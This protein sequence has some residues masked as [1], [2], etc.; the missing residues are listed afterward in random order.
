MAFFLISVERAQVAQVMRK[1]QNL[2]PVTK[3]AKV[4]EFPF[5]YLRCHLIGGVQF[6]NLS[7][8]KVFYPDSLRI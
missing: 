3:Q 5:R 6:W 1:S 7:I 4:L 8:I 2:Q